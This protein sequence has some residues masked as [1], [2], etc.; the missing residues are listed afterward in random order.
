MQTE[1][2][3]NNGQFRE[4]GY[5]RRS[6]TQCVLDTTIRKHIQI[7]YGRHESSDKQLEINTNRT[8]FSCGYCSGHNNT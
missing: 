2:S 8:S 4:T 6:Q 1:R 3:M 7:M 5:T